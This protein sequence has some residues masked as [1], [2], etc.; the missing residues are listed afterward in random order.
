V[1]ADIGI[2][3]SAAQIAGNF[4]HSMSLGYGINLCTIYSAQF[5]QLI[6][7]GAVHF[8]VDEIWYSFHSLFLTCI[9]FAL[10]RVN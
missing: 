9:S 2:V 6:C 1:T 8:S 10:Q 5:M 4:I 3:D 7:N